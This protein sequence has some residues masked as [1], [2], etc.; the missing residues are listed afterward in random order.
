MTVVSH[1][2]GETSDPQSHSITRVPWWQFR[3][4]WLCL[5]IVQ[6]DMQLV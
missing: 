2:E 3:E 6:T 1:H 5:V 4:P